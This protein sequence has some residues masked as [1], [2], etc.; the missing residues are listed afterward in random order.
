[1][2]TRDRAWHVATLGAAA[3]RATD[4][5][6]LQSVLRRHR[7][8]EFLR[9]GG[10]DLLGLA[11]IDETVREITALA[12]GA[13][14]TA[15]VR[16]RARLADEW[17]EPIVDGRPAGFVVLGMGKLGG[18]ELNHSSERRPRPRLRGRRRLSRAHGPG[19]L[20]PPRE[21]TRALGGS[22]RR[23]SASESTCASA[24]GGGGGP[25][26]CRCRRA[27]SHYET[28]ARRGSAPCG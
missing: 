12:E 25:W 28:W 16:I 19:V 21:V 10:R 26:R 15:V 23:A 22:P 17:G 6:A 18:E 11:S 5:V 1:V 9:I 8:R 13:I 24:P 14:E 4:R 3:A 7:Q 27:H 20:L 2:R